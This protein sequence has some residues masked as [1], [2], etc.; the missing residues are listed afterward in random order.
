MHYIL[1]AI[2]ENWMRIPQNVL[3]DH[4]NSLQQISILEI[5]SNSRRNVIKKAAMGAVISSFGGILPS[6]I[7]SQIGKAKS[8]GNVDMR[9]VG[10]QLFKIRHQC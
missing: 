8:F 5:M 7:L 1:V 9:K 10:N 2:Q 4:K 3:N 6:F